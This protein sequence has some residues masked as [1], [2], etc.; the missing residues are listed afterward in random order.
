MKLKWFG[1][2]SLMIETEGKTIYI[3]PYQG[4]YDAKAD[5]VVITHG[6]EDHLSPAKLAM[7]RKI[8]TIVVTAKSCAK[9]IEG[10]VVQMEAGEKQRF[11]GVEIEA[12]HSYNLKRFRSPGTPFHPKGQNIAVVLR[13]EGKTIFHASDTDLIP[14]MKNLPPID[15]AFLPIGDT[16]TMDV[17]EAVEAT[18]AI[19]PKTVVPIH[20]RESN[21]KDFQKQVEEKSSVKVA[22][23]KQG[24]E[25]TI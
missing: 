7:V 21:V 18:L 11:D 2:A 6:H 16:Y 4:E 3:D 5:I 8:D 23:L 10:K 9:D 15:I 19:K 25:L 1:H 12:V 13:S 14:E 17:P 20:R 22:A 24:E